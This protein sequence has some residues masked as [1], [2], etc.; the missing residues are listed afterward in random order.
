[1][2]T[3]NEKLGVSRSFQEIFLYLKG[4]LPHRYKSRLMISLKR[5]SKGLMM[6]HCSGVGLFLGC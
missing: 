5:N 1:M 4:L 3:V 2:Y 6:D